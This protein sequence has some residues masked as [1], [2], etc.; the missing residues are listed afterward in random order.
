MARNASREPTL[1]E[2]ARRAQLIDVTV[3]IIAEH[4]N[5]GASLARIAEG[6]GITK[7]AVLYHFGSK[8]AV[9]RA[10][11]ESVLAQLVEHVGG[12]VER[13]DPAGA[14][15]AYVRSMVGHLKEHPRHIRVIIAAVAGSDAHRSAER[16]GPL[17]DLMRA[18]RR[19]RGAVS[20]PDLRTAA[21]IVGGGIDAIVAEYLDHP[22]YD[23]LPAAEQLVDM[24]ERAV[25]S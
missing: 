13:A 18:A 12:A 6:A 21:L 17:A 9:V 15:A 22:D 8:D 7:A 24:M 14:P 20:D 5:A 4:G 11:H 10:A 19:A 25:L 2:R 23:P 16:W 1:T 3:G